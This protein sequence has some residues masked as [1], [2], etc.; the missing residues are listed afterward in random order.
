MTKEEMFTIKAD[1][2]SLKRSR[3]VIKEL[4]VNFPRDSHELYHEEE[5]LQ[6]CNAKIY[7]DKTIIRMQRLFE[8]LSRQ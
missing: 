7:L 3:R 8:K 1:I 6:L 4:I 2:K 5:F